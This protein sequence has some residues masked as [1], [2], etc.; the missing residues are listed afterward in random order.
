[1]ERFIRV[2]QLWSWLP[3]FRAVGETQHLRRAAESLHISPSA[4]SRSVGLLEDDVASALFERVGRGLSLTRAGSTLLTATRDAMRMI[5]DALSAIASGALRGEVRIAAP[6][7]VT[8]MYL[9]P[10]LVGV[11]REHPALFPILEV[12][13]QAEL[14]GR[15]LRGELDLALSTEP[16]G[17]TALTSTAIG[18]YSSG[19]YCGQGHPLFAGEEVD[20]DD[21]ADHP[22]VAPPA[23]ARGYPREGWPVEL[24]RRVE[25]QA[26][27]LQVGVEVCRSGTHLA[28]LPD[29][30]AQ[31]E[32]DRG[33]L[34]RIDLDVIPPTPFFATHRPSLGAKG[35][36]EVLIAAVL[37]AAENDA[38]SP[39]PRRE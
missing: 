17:D 9:L 7:T 21:L 32:V 10:A 25:I 6:G 14:A 16:V 12:R 5:D 38:I 2:S 13:P 31:V 19:V 29:R 34:R 37:A 1:M 20:L 35:P 22:F 33:T 28:V 3:A 26:A 11:H 30:I 36:A 8:R 24:P 39:L 27:D 18:R 4:L 15:L 23:D